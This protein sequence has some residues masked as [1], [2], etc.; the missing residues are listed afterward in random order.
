MEQTYDYLRFEIFQDDQQIKSL[1][2]ELIKSAQ[3]R[4]NAPIRLFGLGVR[5]PTNP[6]KASSLPQLTLEL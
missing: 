3:N 5:F 1:F 2:Q 6:Q 4:R